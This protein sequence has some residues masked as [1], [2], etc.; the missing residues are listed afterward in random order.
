M[1]REAKPRSANYYGM[2]SEPTIGAQGTWLEPEEITY[3][4]G[5]MIRRCRAL[6]EDGKLRVIR[7][8]IPDTFFSIRASGGFITSKEDE[9]SAL[10]VFLYHR[11]KKE[12]A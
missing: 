12:S 10:P 7:C 11:S 9:M 3:P 5:A 1:A 4:S 2:R 6:C 8:G